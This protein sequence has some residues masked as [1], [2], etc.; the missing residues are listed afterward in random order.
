MSSR[1]CLA[2]ALLAS[3]LVLG[4]C[5]STGGIA[6]QQARLDANTLSPGAALAQARREAGW[7][8]ES[9]WQQYHDPQLD[10]WIARALEHSPSLDE[11][12][13]R[14]RQAMALAEVTRAAEAPQI[15]ASASLRRQH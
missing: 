4:G 9:W 7:P 1:T 8:R 11:A 13:A 2:G 14:V 5:M 3:A 12:E 6:P 15:G 10:A